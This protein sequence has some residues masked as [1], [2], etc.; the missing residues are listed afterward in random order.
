MWHPFRKSCILRQVIFW[1]NY[2]C[3]TQFNGYIFLDCTSSLIGKPSTFCSTE[4][5][6]TSQD[7]HSQQCVEVAGL[8]RT[9]S[10]SHTPVFLSLEYNL[11]LKFVIP[12]NTFT[13]LPFACQCKEGY[14]A[15]HW[16]FLQES[17]E[18]YTR[19]ICSGI[20]MLQLKWLL[21]K[22]WKV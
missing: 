16:I 8:N 18:W 5:D 14:T 4:K 20:W 12:H 15:L 11:P 19:L 9:R 13:S 1:S 7:D 2:Q 6:A 3:I 10:N 21:W 17:L 22:P